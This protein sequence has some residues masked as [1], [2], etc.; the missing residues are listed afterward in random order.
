MSPIVR[1][2]RR[3]RSDEEGML[4]LA[5]AL[6]ICTVVTVSA[7]LLFN[8]AT[9]NT[10]DATFRLQSSQALYSAEGGIDLAYAAIGQTTSTANLPCGSA[11]LTKTFTESPKSASTSVA[12]WYYDTY[13]VTDAHL[14]CTSVQ[15]G[16][17]TP[18]A[19]LIESVGTSNNRSRYM[20]ALV[21]LTTSSTGSVF[22][23]ALFSQAT[24]TGSNNPTVYGHNGNDANIYT[25]ANLVC[26]NNFVVQGNVI[27]QGSFTGTN[28][29]TVNGNVTAVYNVSL[30]NNTVIGGNLT[31][32]GSGGCSTQ[33]AI[34]MDKNATVDQSAYA[35]CTIT[36]SNNAAVDQTKVQHDTTLTNPTV[37]SFPVVPEPTGT[38]DSGAK[39]AWQAA[40]YSVVTN[41]TCSG[42]GNVYSAI[43]GYTSP[44]AVITSCAMSWSGNSSIS[45]QT[46]VAIFASA[47]F[48]M[49]NNTSWQSNNSTTRLLY[50]IVPSSI[51][52]TTTTCNSGNPGIAL[53][54]NTSFASTINVLDYTPC[55]ISVSNNS[56][57]YGQVYA[58][59]VSVQNNFSQYYV[60][61]PVVPGASGGGQVNGPLAVAV[62]YERQTLSAVTPS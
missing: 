37:E 11:S 51:S 44:T 7:T 34:S 31:A 38:N 28:N 39:T 8:V 54:N 58:G 12:V 55:T 53:Q 42:S 40:G 61:M 17:V 15:N 30:T 35:Y 6:V 59:T 27:A 9:S 4:G 24:M 2:A 49:S 25:N 26:G 47:G 32:T 5:L 1:A 3:A 14:S 57:G 46:N 48:S 22:D 41:N 60:P 18:A 50:L 43:T 36:L 13:P 16:S 23:K 62:A 45:L 29:C 10:G 33:G 20:E 19:A 56:T 52:G 21:K